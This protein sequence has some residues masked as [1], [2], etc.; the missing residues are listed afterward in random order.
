MKPEMSK[1]EFE[2]LAKLCLDGLPIPFTDSDLR[3]NIRNKVDELIESRALADHQ[4][5]FIYGH[6]SSIKRELKKI[7]NTITVEI[8]EPTP[9]LFW[10]LAQRLYWGR[11]YFAGWQVKVTVNG[12][13]AITEPAPKGPN[14]LDVAY[15]TIKARELAEG[16]S[17][18][19]FGKK[20]SLRFA[21]LKNSVDRM[22][23]PIGSDFNLHADKQVP[24]A[25]TAYADELTQSEGGTQGECIELVDKGNGFAK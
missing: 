14:P 16:K 17:V 25:Y 8:L 1:E 20:E 12:Q 10:R 18:K 11:F 19:M 3:V 9:N 24:L 21:N 15:A 7:N 5:R 22:S 23:T 13:S 2:A 6:S 4:N